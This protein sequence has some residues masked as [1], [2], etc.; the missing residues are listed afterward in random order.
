MTSRNC[1]GQNDNRN[2]YKRSAPYFMLRNKNPRCLSIGEFYLDSI[3][4]F[5]DFACFNSIAMF[6]NRTVCYCC[7]HGPNS[8]FTI[9]IPFN[10][11]YRLPLSVAPKI[12]ILACY[13]LYADFRNTSEP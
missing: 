10:S 9:Q 11:V 6:V 2:K 7:Y 5:R 3:N 13:G 4:T 8:L 1:K 12:Y